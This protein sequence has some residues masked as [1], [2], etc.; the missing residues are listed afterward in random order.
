V[1]LLHANGLWALAV[2]WMLLAQRDVDRL[3]A[4]AFGMACLYG[5][6]AALARRWHRDAA[7]HA[8]ALA[9]VLAAA[10]CAIRFSGPWISVALG[11]EGTALIWLGLLES[12]HWLRHAG[13]V[14]LSIAVLLLV[15]LLAQPLGLGS[16]PFLN[17]RS[18]AAA[19]VVALHYVAALL[20]RRLGR[21]PGSLWF[22]VGR[23]VIVAN[24][25]TLLLLS[26]E[27]S[28]YFGWSAWAGRTAR[29]A[30]AMASAELRRQLAL[31]IVWAAYAVVLV[32]V[33][34]RINYRPI[35]FLAIVVFA[36]TTA[37][38]F[39]VDLAELD[40]VSRMLSVIG[41]GLLLLTASYLY[42][43]LL[44]ESE[45]RAEPERPLEEAGR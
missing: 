4:I 6:A 3:S 31:S 23:L 29:G 13:S 25:L 45:S 41:L 36:L 8:T 10:A 20:S 42:Q 27:V 9:A 21:P 39:F 43:R 37:K 19:F 7:L 11:A 22:S 14:F 1:L 26:A 12:R 34:L 28:A 17:D 33:G 2:L 30:G 35:R 40:R 16:W 18:T 32:A 44:N 15:A 24:V 38:V 5:G